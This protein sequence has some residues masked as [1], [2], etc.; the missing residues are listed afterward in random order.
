MIF[1]IDIYYRLFHSLFSCMHS[2]EIIANF[3]VIYQT[4]VCIKACMCACLSFKK[5]CFIFIKVRVI[6][7]R[8][9]D[10]AKRHIRCVVICALYIYRAYILT[11]QNNDSRKISS[12][13]T[14]VL[15]CSFCGTKYYFTFARRQRNVRSI[16]HFT[17]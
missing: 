5:S 11:F 17:H 16:T 6:S 3:I 7:K 14:Y 1:I 8:V 13:F 15:Y 4:S 2:K 10:G 9:F 12:F